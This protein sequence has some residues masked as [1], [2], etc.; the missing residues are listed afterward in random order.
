LNTVFLYEQPSNGAGIIAFNTETFAFTPVNATYTVCGDVAGVDAAK[1]Y[2]NVTTF[3][4]LNSSQVHA[5]YVSYW[6]FVTNEMADVEITWTANKTV[7]A[8]DWLCKSGLVKTKPAATTICFNSDYLDK[9]GAMHK[10][11]WGTTPTVD[12]CFNAVALTFN[13]ITI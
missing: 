7:V 13:K 10:Y 8:G 2:T 9:Y 12:A 1:A 4:M 3:I 6:N 5:K 11:E